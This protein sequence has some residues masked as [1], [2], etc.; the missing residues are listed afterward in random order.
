MRF[1]P[2]SAG[3]C[4]KIRVVAAQAFEC[5]ERR[6]QGEEGSRPTEKRF[7]QNCI[8]WLLILS[9][10]KTVQRGDPLLFAAK[11]KVGQRPASD[12]VL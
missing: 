8:F 5:G 10:F 4:R 12:G 3:K 9:R 11:R 1:F 6:E 2:K 7:I